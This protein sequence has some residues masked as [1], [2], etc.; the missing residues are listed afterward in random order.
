[1]QDA[2]NEVILCITDSYEYKECLRLK[3]MMQDNL[4]IADLIKEIKDL[5]KKYVHSN[6]D[7][8]L[9]DKLDSL[10]KKLLSIPIYAIYMKNLEAVNNKINYVKDELNN[11]FYNILNE[12]DN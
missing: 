1:M 11:Y 7:D 5:Q 2:L 9:G 3:N 6:Y 8:N 4:D 12:Y 10:E